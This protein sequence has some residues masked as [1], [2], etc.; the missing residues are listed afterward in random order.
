MEGKISPEDIVRIAQRDTGNPQAPQPAAVTITQVTELGTVY[1]PAEIQAITDAAH[2]AD[3]P[4]HVDG[5]RISNAA[6]ALGLGLAEATAEL[7]IDVVSLGGAKNGT[8]NAEAI[9]VVNP[10]RAI[11]RSTAEYVRKFSAQL[12]SKLRY[13]SAQLNAIFGTDL[14]LRN[15]THANSM[16]QKLAKELDALPGIDASEPQAN[17]VL[18]ALPEKTFTALSTRYKFHRWGQHPD[19]RP[20]ARLICCWATTNEEIAQLTQTVRELAR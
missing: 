6:A 1:S 10:D 14:W 2:Q 13:S 3:L 5:A 9:I 19:G 16:A 15:A 17:T 12:G 7:G 11:E 18:A 20:L 4:V 8:M